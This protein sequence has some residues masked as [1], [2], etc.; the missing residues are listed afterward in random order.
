MKNIKVIIILLFFLPIILFSDNKINFVT[1]NYPPLNYYENGSLR[2]I[3]VDLLY[4]ILNNMNYKEQVSISVFP[5]ARAYYTALNTS[6]VC[7]FSI[8][9]NSERED[10]FKWVGPIMEDDVI[11]LSKSNKKFKSNSI[12][13][14]KKYKIGVIIDDIGE[15]ALNELGV[16]DNELEFSSSLDS[17]F[18]MLIHDRVDMIAYSRISILWFLKE[19]NMKLQKFHKV[20]TIYEGALFYGFS[21][22]TDQE[23]I[24]KFRKSYNS[25]TNTGVIDD[26]IKKYIKDYYTEF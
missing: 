16:E 15:Q 21:L 6:N 24:S 4:K 11:L 9:K 10:K 25:L 2:G 19:E 23:F 26:I 12:E 7:I 3:A 1:E 17:L 22:Y 5:W 13:E 20:K 8:Y 18:N 14:L